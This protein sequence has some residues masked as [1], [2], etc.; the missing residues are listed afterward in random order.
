MPSR[1]EAEVGGRS[2]NELHR[3]LQRQLRRAGVDLEGD[4]DVAGLRRLLTSVDRSYRE[5]EEYRYTLERSMDVSST[6]MR[7]LY[8][9]LAQASDR[10]VAIE[11]DKLQSVISALDHGLCAVGHNGQILFMNEA[12][13][14][15]LRERPV[16]GTALLSRFELTWGPDASRLTPDEIFRLI[17]GG[18][19]LHN[20][21]AMLRRPDGTLLPVWASITPLVEVGEVRGAVLVFDDTSDY[22]ATLENL[23]KALN[24][25]QRATNAKSQF[26]AN[27]SHEIRTPMNGAIGMLDLLANA[28]LDA[29]AGEFL[30]IARS[31]GEAL[32]EI[33]N[34]IL[35]FS[36][37][38]A[39]RVEVEDVVFDPT[40]LAEEVAALL[41]PRAQ[42]AGVAVRVVV[43]DDVPGWIHG[44]PI[45]LRQVITNLVGNAV[46]FTA[47]G[48][49]T[50]AVDRLTMTNGRDDRLRILVIDTGSGIPESRL[51]SLFDPFSQLD[52]ATTRTHGGT[53]LGL[54]IC[55]ETLALLGGHVVVSSEVGVGSMF[56]FTLPFVEAHADRDD[57]PLE[58][59]PAGL[60]ALVVDDQPFDRQVA[61]EYLR[62][63]DMR[64]VE[65]ESGA[66]AMAKFAMA[67]ELGRPFDVVLA[68]LRMAEQ[69]GLALADELRRR[70]HEGLVVMLMT[71][72]MLDGLERSR[73]NALVDATVLKPMRASDL[74]RLT[75]A[76]WWRRHS[77]SQ[78]AVPE[79][80]DRVPALSA[81]NHTG[82]DPADVP[83]MRDPEGSVGPSGDS[84]R[85][86]P[87][88]RSIR[89]LVAEDNATNQVVIRAMLARFGHSCAVVDN[90][91]DAVKA[92]MQH[93]YDVVLM[94]C[95]MPQM[96]GFAATATIRAMSG[97][98]SRI[99]IVA[100]TANALSGDRQ[101]C[102]DAGMSDYLSKPL[103]V[104]ALRD[105]RE[106]AVHG[107]RV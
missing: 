105:A 106:A 97:P 30:R 102:L 83:V 62:R 99:P 71:A 60:T 64:V 3:T 78:V 8:D 34:G 9:D 68:D 11:H 107:S 90:G 86:V 47:T 100:L 81:D 37:L 88:P 55:K 24:E 52:A 103:K 44:D 66:E 79:P 7:R 4:I 70:G 43:G 46:K 50:I 38:E 40:G 16:D 1:I 93:D 36:K 28:P 20:S 31:S 96:D 84:S 19:H 101:R 26:L 21:A 13:G 63:L 91:D 98:V 59:L 2:D 87:E 22:S 35:D 49:V 73:A 6:E 77:A 76:T 54:A 58:P 67:S 53:G 39:G 69:S 17:A 51:E 72:T 65:A 33:I 94:D 23:A 56:G 32:L 12:A 25:S 57:G 42:S 104:G 61:A 45:R 75:T 29:E 27:M 74:E 92:V 18:Q 5:A 85:P 15:L 10:L 41:I 82:N 80:N 89:V 95:Q 14:G 48:S